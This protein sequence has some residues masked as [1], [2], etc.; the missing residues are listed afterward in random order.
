MNRFNVRKAG[1]NLI[2]PDDIVVD[3]KGFELHLSNDDAFNLG[4]W[5]LIR[6]GRTYGEIATGLT[7]AARE[8]Y[9]MEKPQ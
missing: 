4:V 2:L 8:L 6:T 5:L 9:G 3:A 7:D 1:K